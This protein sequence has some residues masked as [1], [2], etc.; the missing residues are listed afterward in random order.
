MAQAVTTKVTPHQ[1]AQRG[2]WMSAGLPEFAGD[3][4]H[5]RRPVVIPPRALEQ[6]WNRLVALQHLP[7]TAVFNLLLIGVR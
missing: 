5:Q 4:L 3:L 6:G 1:L 7:E 2:R